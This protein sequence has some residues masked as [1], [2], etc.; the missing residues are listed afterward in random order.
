MNSFTLA[1]ISFLLFFIGYSWMLFHAEIKLKL[2]GINTVYC[3]HNTVNKIVAYVFYFY[4]AGILTYA[5]YL[6]KEEAILDF[7]L[8]WGMFTMFVGLPLLVVAIV[9]NRVMQKSE[10]S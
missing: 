7:F 1:S 2:E 6:F 3:T 9:V 5:V 8:A 4:S 10:V